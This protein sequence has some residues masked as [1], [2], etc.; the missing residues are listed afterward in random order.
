MV[1]MVAS[2][3]ELTPASCG[4]L[5][6]AI[7]SFGF[8]TGSFWPIVLKNSVFPNTRILMDENTSVVRCYVKSQF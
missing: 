4:V 6:V 8:V 7:V 5:G 2:T 1:E 3:D